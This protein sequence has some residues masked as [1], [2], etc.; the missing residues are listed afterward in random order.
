[1]STKIRVRFAPSPTGYLHIG[2]VRTALYN[3]LYAR[4]CGGKFIL[5]I[6]DTDTDRSRDNYTRA[7]LSGMEWLGMEPDEGPYYQSRREKIYYNFLEKLI[8]KDAVYKCYCTS[9]ELEEEK[10][11]QNGPGG[12]SGKCRNLSKEDEEKYKK[13]DRDFVYRLKTPENRNI[14]FKDLVK[15]EIQIDSGTLSDFIILKSD[16]MPTYNFACVA[17]DADLNIS[18]VIRG[19]DHISNTPKQIL[20]YEALGIDLPKFAHLPQVHGEDGKKLSKRTGAVSLEEYRKEGYLPGALKNYLALLGWSTSDSQQLFTEE[21]LIRKFD[22]KRCNSSSGIFDREKLDWIN[23]KHIRNLN[24]EQLYEKAIP[25]L[26]KA[27]INPEEQKEKV[28]RALKAEKK[29]IEVLSDIPGRINFLIK[30]NF[31]YREDAVE[32]RLKKEGVREILE[33]MLKI[34]KNVSRFEK[35][36][37][38][39][40]L[41]D[42][43]KKKDIGAGKILHPVRVAVSG[44]MEG[45]GAF[46][47]LEILGRQKVIE[48]IEYT[49]NNLV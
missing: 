8:E 34:F 25:W 30:D 23:G 15:G 7:I 46:E 48:R 43:C 6:E 13:E 26:E 20:I 37:L 47:M 24:V 40:K 42:Y 18:H 12:Y 41:R 21:E 49:I 36:E 31:D 39:N 9:K 35:K 22:I 44:R 33:D 5:R 14:V 27:D 1:M 32:K 11:S 45:P 4:H 38:E 19:D 2:G 17:D 28:L 10:Q 16:G 29:K 3:Y